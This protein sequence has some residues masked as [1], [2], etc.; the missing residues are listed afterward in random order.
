[1]P[2]EA[3]NNWNIEYNSILF[4]ERILSGHSNV[5]SY[6][7]NRDILFSIVRAKG[8]DVTPVIVN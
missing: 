8:G 6:D 3:R 4:F 7:R 5:I 1:M 2:R